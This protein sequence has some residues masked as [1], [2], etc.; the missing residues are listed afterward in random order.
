MAR[1]RI[2]GLCVVVLLLAACASDSG[3]QRARA[4]V[5]AGS[6]REALEMYERE[7]PH[8]PALLVGIASAILERDALAG[9]EPTRRAAFV[10][11]GAAG[12]R[13]RRVLEELAAREDAPQVRALALATLTRLSDARARTQLR[14]LL[15]DQ[16]PAIAD[17]AHGALDPSDHDD[18]SRALAALSSARAERRLAALQVLA[19]A[20]FDADV[21]AALSERSRIDPLPAARA[22]A[23]S[24][25]AGQ[26]AA[27]T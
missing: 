15:D 13:A 5:Q 2:C 7:A 23:V 24:A 17:L 22:A 8:E 27:A 1:E 16:D 4:A 26:G 12:H 11:L 14:A 9:D 3:A 20:S 25:L 21:A 18:L 6:Y 19:R 10:E